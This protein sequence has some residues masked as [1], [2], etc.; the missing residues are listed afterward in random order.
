LEPSPRVL[1][2]DFEQLKLLAYDQI[3][4][5]IQNLSG[6]R[7]RELGKLNGKAVYVRIRGYIQTTDD[8]EIGFSGFVKIRMN[9]SQFAGYCVGD[10]LGTGTA[11]LLGQDGQAFLYSP[12]TAAD[13]PWR[14][15][16]AVGAVL[17]GTATGDISIQEVPTMVVDVLETS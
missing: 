5:W 3:E 12:A 1:P 7:I 17:H 4:E 13:A 10:I 14:E 16:R 2:E 9:G 11:M 6:R 8:D 15:M